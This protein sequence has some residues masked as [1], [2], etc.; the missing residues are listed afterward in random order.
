MALKSIEGIGGYTHHYPKV[1]L[2]VTS[3]ARGRDDAMAV[4]WH[5]SISLNP[6]LYGVSI[7][8]KRYSYELILESEQFGINFLPLQRAEI[9]AAVGGSLGREV[10]KFEKFHIETITSLKVD[11]PIIKDSYAAYECKLSSRHTIGDHE[12]LVGEI[13]ATHFQEEVFTPAGILD[14][15]RVNPALYIGAETYTTTVKDTR[16][17][18]RSR[19]GKGVD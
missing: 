9:I 11:V 7:A 14:L 19:Y 3:R 6:P 18:E 17:L 16:H 15:N 2:I 10:D 4:A 8:A 1:A 12:W 13:L 5:S